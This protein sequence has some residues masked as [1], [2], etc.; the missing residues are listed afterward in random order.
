MEKRFAR[1]LVCN[2][3]VTRYIALYDQ[4]SRA[5]HRRTVPRGRCAQSALHQYQ[6]SWNNPAP[7]LGQASERGAPTRQHSCPLHAPGCRQSILGS[8]QL[9]GLT[10][11]PRAL[12]PPHLPDPQSKKPCAQPVLLGVQGFFVGVRLIDSCAQAARSCAPLISIQAQDFLTC[13]LSC[14]NLELNII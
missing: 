7:G 3:L 14:R 5:L 9:D 13:A 1:P 11:R 10:P 2:S 6:R 8:S 12:K 4:A